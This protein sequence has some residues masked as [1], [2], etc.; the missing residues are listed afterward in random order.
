[1]ARIFRALK[2]AL[3]I[4]YWLSI[5]I[6]LGTNLFSWVKPQVQRPPTIHELGSKAEY[7]TGQCTVSANE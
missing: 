6:A 3:I 2:Q 1:M 5:V 4:T 7:D